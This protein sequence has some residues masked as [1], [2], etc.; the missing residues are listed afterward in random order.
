MI[1][2]ITEDNLG[3]LRTDKQ[4]VVIIEGVIHGPFKNEHVGKI[5]KL[6]KMEEKI[7]E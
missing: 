5:L 3:V 1:R 7:N 2:F 4:F 6:L